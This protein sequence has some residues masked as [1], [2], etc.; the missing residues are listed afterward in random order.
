MTACPRLVTSLHLA[1][2][3]DDVSTLRGLLQQGADVNCPVKQRLPLTRALELLPS[4]SDLTDSE[5]RLEQGDVCTLCGGF[6]SDD[7]SF[8]KDDVI[9]SSPM[10]S[11]P[12][13]KSESFEVLEALLRHGAKLTSQDPL[14]DTAL[15]VAVTRGHCVVRRLVR[16]VRGGGWLAGPPHC[17]SVQQAQQVSSLAAPGP[18]SPAR[19]HEAC[20]PGVPTALLHHERPVAEPGGPQAP[21][22]PLPSA[23]PTLP[24]DQP[25]RTDSAHCEGCD[26]IGLTLSSRD[27]LGLTP[28][29]L[30]LFCGDAKSLR[31][32]LL[33]LLSGHR[34]GP[35]V[36]VA[37]DGLQE[38]GSAVY[39]WD[40]TCDMTGA[41]RPDWRCSVNQACCEG[42]Q[43]IATW[44]SETTGVTALHLVAAANL[45][46]LVALLMTHGAC[47]DTRDALGLTARDVAHKGPEVYLLRRHLLFPDWYDVSWKTELAVWPVTKP[48][49]FGP[50]HVRHQAWRF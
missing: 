30:A 48:R 17:H 21:S 33:W 49:P 3:E 46:R 9:S 41:A 32:L 39:S 19:C 29:E 10:T 22:R 31:L 11:P 34:T 38:T 37:V 20:P 35:D 43:T 8:V 7:G 36:T 14:G 6:L 42:V 28:L 26:V 5:V 25:T 4:H 27:R 47:S 50:Q 18:A 23:A 40:T 2:L 13:N 24:A 45:P 16:V 12:A 15:H 44:R 1:L